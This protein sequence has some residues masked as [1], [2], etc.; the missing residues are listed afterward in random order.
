MNRTQEALGDLVNYEVISEIRP[1]EPPKVEKKAIPNLILCR[2]F[3]KAKQ[4]VDRTMERYNGKVND[5]KQR[6]QQADADIADLQREFKKWKS[7]ASTFLLDRNNPRAVEKQNNAANNANRLLG[8]I[9]NANE[10]R[11]D[12]VER[13]NEA[14]EDANEK[15]EEL[16]EE[17]LV[18]I[19]DDIVAVLDKCLRAAT[20]LSNGRNSEDLVA[21]IELCFIGLKVFHTF[22]EHIDGNVARK[23]ARER[24]GEIN[25]LLIQLFE[26]EDARNY[27]V[28]LFRR[29]TYLVEKNAELY[30]QIVGVIE[31]VNQ[32]E[33]GSLTASLSQALE[34]KFKTTFQYEGIID[35]S[36]LQAVTDEMYK[37]IDAMKANIANIQQLNESTQSVAE[38][39][40]TFHQQNESLLETMKDNKK[41]LADSILSKKSFEC[42][43]IE[44][45]IIEDF[46][47]KDTRPAAKALREHLVSLLGEE[48]IDAMVMESEDRYSIGKAETAI[49]QANLTRLQDQR[50]RVANRI[51]ELSKAIKKIETDLQKAGEVTQKNAD[52]F[53]KETSS[54]YILSHLPVIGFIFALQIGGK[55]KAFEP[56]FRSDNDNYQKLATEVIEKITSARPIS[57]V[58]AGILGIGGM[59]AFFLLKVSSE[60]AVNIGVPGAVIVFYLVTW[61]IFGN[62]NNKLSSYLAGKKGPQTAK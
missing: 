29:N 22:E 40:V 37:S 30:S 6:I 31:G 62:M 42:D 5:F 51:N 34:E 33:L 61:F 56:G 47:A 25:G 53:R 15:L 32:D 14:I 17:A 49:K 2:N 58:L 52:T 18:V 4:K 3:E 21:G 13:H 12:L 1:L 43:L 50:N 46:Y 20:K 41:G 38:S 54:L 16:T 57:L 35:P 19:D 24:L 7:K 11:N 28:D 27:L 45:S 55:V 36:Q 60:M 8:K 26:N 9:E 23:D 44:E 59:I 10:K 39:A 48:Q